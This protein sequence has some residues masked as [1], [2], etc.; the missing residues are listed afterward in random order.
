[1]KIKYD[2]CNKLK[3]KIEEKQ[4]CQKF[5]FKLTRIAIYNPLPTS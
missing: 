2:Y 3:T 5:H 1:M 4:F